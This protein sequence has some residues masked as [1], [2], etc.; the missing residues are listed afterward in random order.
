[1]EIIFQFLEYGLELHCVLLSRRLDLASL[2]CF[3]EGTA[4]ENEDWNNI[5]AM[6]LGPDE[7]HTILGCLL[8]TYFYSILK[9]CAPEGMQTELLAVLDRMLVYV[10]EPYRFRKQPR[11]KPMMS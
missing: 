9:T 11:Q 1:V 8:G 4:F 7:L 3:L 10:V 5:Y 2:Q 6:F